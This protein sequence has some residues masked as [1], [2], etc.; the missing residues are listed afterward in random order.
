MNG[1]KLTGS[2][3]YHATDVLLLKHSLLKIITPQT[4]LYNAKI[5]TY[6]SQ[7]TH[8]S[9]RFL[10]YLLSRGHCSRPQSFNQFDTN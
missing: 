9:H 3:M 10:F 2:M 5:Q 7:N 8:D 1:H 6:L 4:T